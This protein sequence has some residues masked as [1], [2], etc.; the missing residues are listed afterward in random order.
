MKTINAIIQKLVD[1]GLLTVPSVEK[2]SGLDFLEFKTQAGENVTVQCNERG[3]VGIYYKNSQF[4]D[5]S[6]ETLARVL[7]ELAKGRAVL[8]EDNDG[9]IY[10][11]VKLQDGKMLQP[12]RVKRKRH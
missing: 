7:S 11:G 9:Y 6:D 3:L 4:Y 12:E 2:A 10:Y 1:D 5:E 8:L